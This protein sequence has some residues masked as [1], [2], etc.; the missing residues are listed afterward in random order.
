MAK[1][2]KVGKKY[3]GEGTTFTISDVKGN[4]SDYKIYLFGHF[5]RYSGNNLINFS[6]V[7]LTKASSTTWTLN[8]GVQLNTGTILLYWALVKKKNPSVGKAIVKKGSGKTKK[9]LLRPNISSDLHVLGNTQGNLYTYY[10]DAQSQ[11]FQV[12]GGT[13][14]EKTIS[15]IAIKETDFV[16]SIKLL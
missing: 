2:Y 7:K 3:V 15:W 8:P 6:N 13:S 9:N 10:D 16:M 11:W 5:A 1:A 14:P 4:P 12:G